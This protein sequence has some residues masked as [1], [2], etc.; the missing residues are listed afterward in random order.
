MMKVGFV[1]VWTCVDPVWTLR[2]PSVDP[3]AAIHPPYTY[4]TE[5][6]TCILYT[7]LS[8]WYFDMV[9]CKVGG[10]LCAGM[11]CYQSPFSS[12]DRTLWAR[13]PPRS[14][15]L[16]VSLKATR[17]A[18]SSQIL[19]STVQILRRQ[20]CLPKASADGRFRMSISI[21]II[22]WFSLSRPFRG[23]AMGIHDNN[24]VL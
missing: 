15:P 14:G 10:S 17:Q 19:Y 12:N 24:P 18:C 2:G 21:H 9:L 11:S 3:V 22:M 13:P 23:W 4:F 7:A 1:R 16:P 8:T 20:C 6:C 5:H